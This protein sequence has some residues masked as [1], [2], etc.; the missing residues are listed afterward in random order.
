M[1][2]EGNIVWDT[3]TVAEIGIPDP[4]PEPDTVIWI[5]RNVCVHCRAHYNWLQRAMA[6]FLLGWRVER[7]RK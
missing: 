3:I 5:A 2:A 7:V 1:G 6:R 4:P